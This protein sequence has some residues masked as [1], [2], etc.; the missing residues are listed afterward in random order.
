[1]FRRILALFSIA[2]VAWSTASAGLYYEAV[3]TTQGKGSDGMGNVKVKAWVDGKNA[4][5][6]FAESKNEMMGKGTYLLTTDGGA[7]IYL[8]NPKEKTYAV[9]DM[10]AMMQLAGGAMGMVKMT[11]TDPKIE[12][13]AEEPGPALLGYPTTHYKSRTSYAM[14]M[15]VMGMK[16]QSSIVKDQET[17]ATTALADP[18]LGIWL[19]N[20]PASGNEQLDKLVAA[21]MATMKGVPLKS[22]TVTTTTDTKKKKAETSTTTMEVTTLQTLDIAAS[23][24]AIPDG[25]REEQMFPM[26]EMPKKE[27]GKDEGRKDEST[28]EGNPLRRVIKKPW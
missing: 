6:E 26:G 13:L 20:A 16:T 1:M 27:A 24:F 28:D 8:V 15:S 17:W 21:E 11:I 14:A 12:R 18:G 9:W 22:V 23:T 4:K 5:V 2:A 25:Y 7:T 19:R 10:A 3:T